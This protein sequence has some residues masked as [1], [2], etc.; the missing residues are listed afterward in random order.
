MNLIGRSE[1]CSIA[2]KTVGDLMSLLG[3][4]DLAVRR[5]VRLRNTVND[6]RELRDHLNAEMG[7]VQ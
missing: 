2:G 4:G 5:A 7:C 6:A 3:R 1:Y